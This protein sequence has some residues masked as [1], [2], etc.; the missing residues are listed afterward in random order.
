MSQTQREQLVQDDLW[1]IDDAVRRLADGRINNDEAVRIIEERIGR[2][3]AQPM[4]LIQRLFSKLFG[5]HL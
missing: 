4:G 1:A 5:T 2:S 3:S